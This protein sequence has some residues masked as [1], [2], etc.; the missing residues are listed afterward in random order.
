[1]TF[2][3][4]K[5]ALQAAKQALET[6]Q[7]IGAPLPAQAQQ[8]VD[9]FTKI[10]SANEK[11]A[12]NEQLIINELPPTLDEI[13]A[14][15]KRLR[16]LAE[17]NINN[18]KLEIA[19]AFK[20]ELDVYF[21]NNESVLEKAGKAAD[22]KKANQKIADLIASKKQTRNGEEL[23]GIIKKLKNYKESLKKLKE[24]LD[25]ANGTSAYAELRDSFI[26]L[27]TKFEIYYDENK[28]SQIDNAKNA[29]YKNLAAEYLADI[30]A[31]QNID[32]EVKKG[33]V[34]WSYTAIGTSKNETIEATLR[35]K[36]AVKCVRGKW[37]F[38]S[39]SAETGKSTNTKDAVGD[40]HNIAPITVSTADQANIA[41]PSCVLNI[42]VE[43]GAAKLSGFNPIGLLKMV[44]AEPNSNNPATVVIPDQYK[45][46]PAKLP[47]A[48]KESKTE[49]NINDEI[50]NVLASF[51]IEGDQIMLS[52]LDGDLNTLNYRKGKVAYTSKCESAIKINPQL[53]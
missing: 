42:L 28:K 30:A 6:I 22:E 17:N 16:G 2:Q 51:R 34:R 48:I 53:K 7:K 50:K 4:K 1:M 21:T 15:L 25:K 31:F 9:F 3:S 27:R 52:R 45:I 38:D 18:G 46:N 33:T 5:E 20:K 26:E 39:V 19:E 43:R 40:K 23:D 44:E 14:E 24:E 13:L 49:K 41:S 12:T 11:A 36:F 35:V 29:L 8:L 10:M 32:P 47:D 37:Y